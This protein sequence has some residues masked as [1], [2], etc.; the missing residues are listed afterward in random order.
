MD[1][2][3]LLI[4]CELNEVGH[5]LLS[6]LFGIGLHYRVL[7]AVTQSWQCWR[8]YAGNIKQKSA[9]ILLSPVRIE[10]GPPARYSPNRTR[11]VLVERYLT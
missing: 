9:K 5:C 1:C 8:C 7:S 11:Q 2:I 4:F 6:E 3:F 10:L